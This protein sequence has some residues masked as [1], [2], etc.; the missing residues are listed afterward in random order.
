MDKCCEVGSHACNELVIYNNDQHRIISIDKCLIPEIHS[1]WLRGVTTIGCC[2]GHDGERE[3]YIQVDQFDS[4]KME[5]LGYIRQQPKMGTD[6]FLFGLDC[7][8]PK[9]DFGLLK[10]FSFQ[11]DKEMN[12]DD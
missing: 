9:T 6:G 7:F 10:D 1:L 3:P 11:C 8:T 12:F 2:C 5:E 4:E